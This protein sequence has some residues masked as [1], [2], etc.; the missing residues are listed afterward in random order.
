MVGGERGVTN[1]GVCWDRTS[2]RR[3][4]LL[5]LCADV[6]D[7]FRRAVPDGPPSLLAW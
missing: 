4:S 3:R 5:L 6:A 7:F 1:A 2:A